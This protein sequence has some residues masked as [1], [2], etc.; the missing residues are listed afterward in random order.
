VPSSS[1]HLH[2]YQ[3]MVK[4]LYFMISDRTVGARFAVE[5]SGAREDG[6]S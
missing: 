4:P 6:G 1:V 5:A 2:T 3:L